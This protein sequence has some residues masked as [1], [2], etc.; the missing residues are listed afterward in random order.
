M[1]NLD[2]SRT[3]QSSQRIWDDEVL[4]ALHDY[5]RIPNKSPAYE[6]DWQA[7]MD[8]A[9][10]LIDAWCHKQPVDRLTVDVVRLEKRTQVI[11]MEVAGE[12]PETDLLYGHRDNQN[13]N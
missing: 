2:T 4:A 6:P 8:R 3:L 1:A 11:L 7:N 5:I 10:A 12:S 9:V 13:E